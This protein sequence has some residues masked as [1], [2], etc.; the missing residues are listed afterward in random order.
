M[1]PL[2]FQDV[3]DENFVRLLKAIREEPEPRC[4]VNR[5][6]RSARGIVREWKFERP[7]L[8]K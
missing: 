2:S 3:P 1:D 8:L 5:A 4:K 7:V 6:T